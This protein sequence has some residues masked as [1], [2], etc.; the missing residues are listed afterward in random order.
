M[1]KPIYVC[2]GEPAGSLIMFFGLL[3]VIFCTG[4]YINIEVM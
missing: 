3:S 4:S 1:N 2:V